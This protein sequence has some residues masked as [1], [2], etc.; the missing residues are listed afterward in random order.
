MISMAPQATSNRVRIH[1]CT[2][3]KKKS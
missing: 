2:H 3:H 1:S